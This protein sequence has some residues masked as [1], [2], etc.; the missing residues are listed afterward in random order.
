[1]KLDRK[2]YSRLP[3]L[4]STIIFLNFVPKMTFLRKFGPRTSMQSA[5]FRMKIHTKSIHRCWFWIP[6]LFSYVASLN[7]LFW[8]NLVS[9][10][11]SALFK[12]KLSTKGYSEVKILNS[13]V[14]FWNFTPKISLLG[15]IW[16]Q[17]VKVLYLKWILVQRGIQGCW[18]RSI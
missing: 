18:L 3:I 8:V 16:S 1:M 7:Y 12:I 15:K 10:L 13:T 17:N 11:Q 4:N 9:K 5:L 14:V 2:G 6:Q